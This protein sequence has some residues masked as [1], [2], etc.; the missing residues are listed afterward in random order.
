MVPNADELGPRAPISELFCDTFSTADDLE[1]FAALQPPRVR[2]KAMKTVEWLRAC[3]RIVRSRPD[4]R[5]PV[6]V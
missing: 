5:C 3:P 4:R 1:A 6:A 2:A